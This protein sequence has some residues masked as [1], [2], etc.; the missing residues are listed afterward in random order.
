MKRDPDC[1]FCK[2]VAGQI[3]AEKVFEDER[4]LGFRDIQPA[5][6]FHALLIPKEHIATLDDVRA[7]HEPLMG[8][9]IAAAGEIA[10]RHGLRDGYRLVANCR[11]SAGQAVFHLHF[12]VLAGRGFGWPPG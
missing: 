10:A 7:E 9:L 1:I 11:E 4:V 3:P 6:P 8:R 5:A 2:I 12:H